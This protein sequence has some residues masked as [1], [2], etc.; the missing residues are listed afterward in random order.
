MKRYPKKAEHTAW[1]IIDNE[2]VIVSPMDSDVTIL[3]GAATSMWKLM[4]GSRDIS[5]I[6]KELCEEFEVSIDAAK[7]DAEEFVED[8]AGKK[9]ITISDRK[10]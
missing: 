10:R 3:N 7:K 8:L 5:Q 6:A 1:R 4:D 2:A 9:L